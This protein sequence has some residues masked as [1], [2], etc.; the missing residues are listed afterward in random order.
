MLEQA[1]HSSCSPAHACSLVAMVRAVAVRVSVTATAT[2]I[3]ISS[4][5]PTAH[6]PLVRRHEQHWLRVMV[7]RKMSVGIDVDSGHAHRSWDGLD[8]HQ[9]ILCL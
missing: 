7:V 5:L 2:A 6:C 1:I 3:K 4:S 8:A 9:W